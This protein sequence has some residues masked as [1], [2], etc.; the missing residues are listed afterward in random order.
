M[1]GDAHARVAGEVEE[2]VAGEVG[3]G[4]LTLGGGRPFERQRVIVA[5]RVDPTRTGKV[6]GKFSSPSRNT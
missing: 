5:K 6:P 3:D 4:G 1:V 2:S